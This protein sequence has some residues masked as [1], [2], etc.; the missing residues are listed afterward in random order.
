[1]NI[2]PEIAAHFEEDRALRRDLHAHPE[3][4]YEETRTAGIIAEKLRSWGIE[5]HEGIGKTGVVGILK[6]GTGTG[7]IGL[8]LIV[9]SG[10]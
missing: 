2:L 3:I 4:A 7:R 10:N 9:V 6:N 8:G 1:M 5:V